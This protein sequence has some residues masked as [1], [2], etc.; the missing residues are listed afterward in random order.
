MILNCPFLNIFHDRIL[1]FTNR[2]KNV[3]RDHQQ[4]LDYYLVEALKE[5]DIRNLEDDVSNMDVGLEVLDQVRKVVKGLESVAM[6]ETEDG[7][8]I[9]NNVH[10]FDVGRLMARLSMN[11]GQRLK[12]Y[13]TSNS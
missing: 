1:Y 7:V 2:L 3:L 5:S 11:S 13:L 6:E 10:K 4:S 12:Q 8:K 9:K